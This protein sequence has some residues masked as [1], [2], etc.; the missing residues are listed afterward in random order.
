M[1]STPEETAGTARVLLRHARRAVLGTHSKRFAGFPYGSAVPLCLDAQGHPVI[2]VSNLAAHTQNLKADPRV[3]VT[4]HGDDVVTGARCTLLGQAD[5]LDPDEPGARR[6]LSIFPAAQSF[7]DLGD[8]H[9]YRVEPVAGHY[10]GGFGDIR[11]FDGAPYLLPVLPIEA[12]E[13]DII[14]HMNADHADTMRAYCASRFGTEPATVRMAA[15]DADGFDLLADDAP[16]RFDFPEPAKDA[17][18]ARRLLV[19]LAQTSRGT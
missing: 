17:D 3:A 8:F 5:L 18:A 9:F 10:I 13:T 2:L 7:V 12:R 19:R 1:A 15:I 6:Y 14:D 11:W 4:V 16:L